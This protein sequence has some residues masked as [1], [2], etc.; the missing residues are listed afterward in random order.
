MHP[1]LTPYWFG[2]FLL[3]IETLVYCQH[4]GTAAESEVEVEQALPL[5]FAM[6]PAEKR[7]DFL[8]DFLFEC[9]HTVY[10]QMCDD[11]L[12]S[13]RLLRAKQT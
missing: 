3:F 10:N 12:G 5:S 2:L 7:H 6:S 9:I 11:W 4:N 1:R 13:S 8:D